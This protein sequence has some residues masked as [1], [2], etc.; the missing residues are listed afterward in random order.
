MVRSNIK[1]LPKKGVAKFGQN[2]L[3]VSV[4][5]SFLRNNEPFLR[6]LGFTQGWKGFYVF[7]GNMLMG[8]IL[9]RYTVQKRK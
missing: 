4:G 7:M 8:S 6:Y 5:Y 2:L 1:A 9:E 3:K